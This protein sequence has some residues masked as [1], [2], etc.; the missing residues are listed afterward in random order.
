MAKRSVSVTHEA[1][2][3]VLT[4]LFR[5]EGRY[6]IKRR[7][8]VDLVEH[9]GRKVIVRALGTGEPAEARLLLPIAWQ[10]LD[11]EFAQARGA[12]SPVGVAKSVIATTE[13]GA[14]PSPRY[15]PD[16]VTP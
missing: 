15:G 3:D 14:S 13:A 12:R 5:R 6:S 9:F 4:G 10:K 11:E 1:E 7:V 8:P 2:S 16:D